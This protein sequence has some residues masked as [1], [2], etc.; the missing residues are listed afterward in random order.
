MKS[1][2]FKKFTIV[3]SVCLLLLGCLKEKDCNSITPK[4]DKDPKN[5]SGD[6]NV[7]IYSNQDMKKI[8]QVL[9]LV[10]GREYGEFFLYG[11]PCDSPTF[12]SVPIRTQFLANGPHTV[13]TI[14]KD[15]NFKIICRSDVN[16][17]FNNEL[18]SIKIY[19]GY[20]LG[21]DFHFQALSLSPSVNYTVEVN[22]VITDSVVYS[23]TFTGDINA[24]VPSDAFLSDSQFYELTVRDSTGN[25]KFED[26]FGRD[27]E[28]EAEEGFKE[29]EEELNA[30]GNPQAEKTEQN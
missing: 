7:M 26:L 19:N 6:V 29:D 28:R 30:V 17:I 16:V 2:M 1:L 23:S 12:V 27:I 13:S 9:A 22:N 11:D 14:S 25:I 24:A 21:E 4:F 15:Y 10:D 8:T 18:S 5:L 20:T 3:C